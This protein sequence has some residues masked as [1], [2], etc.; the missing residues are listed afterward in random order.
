MVETFFPDSLLEELATKTKSYAATLL[1]PSRRRDV[2]PSDIAY[3]LAM[4]YYMGIVKLP[5]KRDYWRTENDFWPTHP[6]AQNIS[7]DMFHYIWRYI[8]FKGGGDGPD[9][10]MEEE[11][12]DDERSIGELDYVAAQE[13]ESEDEDEEDEE[14]QAA[15]AANQEPQDLS[16]YHKVSPFLEHIIRV[17]QRLCVRP[18]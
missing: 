1:P 9:V 7:R 18:G 10:E 6:V 8:H 13:D 15:V 16:W 14:E 4:Y 11:E 3:F 2:K 5:A 12:D 17:S